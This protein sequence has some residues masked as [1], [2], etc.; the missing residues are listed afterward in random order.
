MRAIPPLRG[1]PGSHKMAL[2]SGTLAEFA[3]GAIAEVCVLMTG[4]TPLWLCRHYCVEYHQM[5]VDQMD[6][7]Q[8]DVDAE[9]R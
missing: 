4:V 2:T 8:I 7:E 3:G 6:V 9:P 1:F 5:D